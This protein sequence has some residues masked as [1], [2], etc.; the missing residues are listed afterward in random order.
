MYP[1]PCVSS[2]FPRPTLTSIPP[3]QHPASS[4]PAINIFVTRVKKQCVGG[5]GGLRDHFK[6]GMLIL[7]LA[8]LIWAV[9]VRYLSGNKN[10]A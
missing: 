1:V 5:P 9:V 8:K 7:R 4:Q 3:S 6:L 10:E 2:Q